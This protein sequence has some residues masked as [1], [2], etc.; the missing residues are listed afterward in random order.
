MGKAV[1]IGSIEFHSPACDNNPTDE[2]IK[3]YGN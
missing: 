2:P 1:S 3:G